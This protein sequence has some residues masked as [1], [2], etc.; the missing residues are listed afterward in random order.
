MEVDKGKDY[1]MEREVWINVVNSC[2]LIAIEKMMKILGL[3]T[4]LI[5]YCLSIL[6]HLF[7][8]NEELWFY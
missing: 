2:S 6:S 1:N 5:K 4:K 7:I 8:F 3:S